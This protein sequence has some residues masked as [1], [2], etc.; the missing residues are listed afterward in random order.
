MAAKNK[1]A[2]HSHPEDGVG[3]D[4]GLVAD[5]VPGGEAQ[6]DDQLSDGHQELARPEQCEEHEQERIAAVGQQGRAGQGKVR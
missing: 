3:M 6:R 5:E 4:L 2:L 1:H